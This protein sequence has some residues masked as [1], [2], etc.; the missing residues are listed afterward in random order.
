MKNRSSLQ[1]FTELHGILLGKKQGLQAGEAALIKE[2]DYAGITDRLD[3]E[4]KRAEWF[5]KE[6]GPSRELD[7]FKS[8]A[9]FLFQS[10]D[11]PAANRSAA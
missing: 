10:A 7:E 1:R 2:L 9:T 8:L 4:K 5:E 6:L 11:R 3:R